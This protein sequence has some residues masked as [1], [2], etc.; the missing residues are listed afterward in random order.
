M[1]MIAI[2]RYGA[3]ERNDRFSLEDESIHIGHNVVV[4]T[5]RGVE[6]GLVMKAYTADD[7]EKTV[8]EILRKASQA[9]YEKYEDIEE[10]Q[11]I[12]EF[13]T[14]KKLIR[15]HGTDVS[16]GGGRDARSAPR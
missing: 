6:W 14:C 9:D 3:M 4:R 13:Q 5:P 2:V 16:D 11:E 12:E 7:G 8:G 15:K 10:R 1:P